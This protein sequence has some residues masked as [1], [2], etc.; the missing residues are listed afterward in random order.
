LPELTVDVRLFRP[1]VEALDVAAL[2][3]VYVRVVVAD[4]VRPEGSRVERLTTAAVKPNRESG[5]SVVVVMCH[6]AR[7]AV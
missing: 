7:R 3:F 5:S 6:R 4:Q 1:I 2:R